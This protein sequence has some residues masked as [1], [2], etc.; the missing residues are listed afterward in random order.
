MDPG[1]FTCLRLWHHQRDVDGNRRD[2]RIGRGFLIALDMA[3]VNFLFCMRICRKL[4]G[5]QQC[6]LFVATVINRIQPFSII[7][8]S[9][10]YSDSLLSYCFYFEGAAS[11]RLNSSQ[12]SREYRNGTVQSRIETAP[13][14]VGQRC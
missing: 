12:A 9:Y 4:D 13:T 10:I 2:V 6:S 7:R 3:L 8:V 5:K 14:K 1:S 11:A